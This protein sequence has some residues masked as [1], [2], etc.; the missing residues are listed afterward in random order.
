[1]AAEV[2]NAVDVSNTV[3]GAAPA[4]RPARHLATAFCVHN[5]VFEPESHVTG[6]QCHGG[7][8]ALT[9]AQAC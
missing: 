7:L 4:G 5:D 1:M 2:I 9:V 6:T 3:R 8:P